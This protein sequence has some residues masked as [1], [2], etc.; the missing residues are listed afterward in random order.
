M[1]GMYAL[2]AVLGAIDVQSPIPKINL[3]PTKLAEFLG[4]QAMTICKEDRCAVAWAVATSL[5]RCLD[6]PFNLILS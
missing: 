6:Q 2:S 4:T 1:Q 3:G 5:A